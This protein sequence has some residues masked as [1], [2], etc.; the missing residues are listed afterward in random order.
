MVSLKVW[1][2][3]KCAYSKKPAFSAT[4]EQVLY[5]IDQDV[6]WSLLLKISTTLQARQAQVLISNWFIKLNVE[7]ANHAVVVKDFLDPLFLNNG[8]SSLC[9]WHT[10][11]LCTMIWKLVFNRPWWFALSSMNRG[12]SLAI[13]PFQRHW[14][15]RRANK[16]IHSHLKSC[17]QHLLLCLPSLNYVTDWLQMNNSHFK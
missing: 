6:S 15:C 9:C 3:L 17:R 5:G 10:S 4:V 7:H 14:G 16:G 2:N 12:T 13:Y 8:N 1:T 11:W